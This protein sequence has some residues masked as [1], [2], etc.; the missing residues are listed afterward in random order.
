MIMMSIQIV[1][2]EFIFQQMKVL[3]GL[4]MHPLKVFPVLMYQLR[5]NIRMLVLEV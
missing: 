2:I 3:K 4:L 5:H 1:I